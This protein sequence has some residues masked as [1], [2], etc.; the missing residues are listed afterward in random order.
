MS[1][2]FKEEFG[3][4][5]SNYITNVRINRAMDYLKQGHLKISEVM[6]LTGFNS[7]NYFSKVFKQHFGLPPSK[8][9]DQGISNS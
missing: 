1:R 6:R 9:K 3:Q 7:L 2:A 5:I 4:N 8:I